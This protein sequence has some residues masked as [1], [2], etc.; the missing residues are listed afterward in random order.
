M[1]DFLGIFFQFINEIHID[2]HR[3]LIICHYIMLIMFFIII[4]LL[5]M[6]MSKRK[7]IEAELNESKKSLQNNLNFLRLV[8][9]TVP[10]PIFCKNSDGVYIEFNSEFEK[11][12]GLTREEILN[13]TAYDL[14]QGEYSKVYHEADIALM[15][16]RGMQTYESKVKYSDGKLHDIHFRKA[17]II[18][19]N[20]EVDGLVGIMIDFTDLKKNENKISRLLKINEAMLEINQSILGLDNINQ[21]F[22]LIL[23]KAL[24]IIDEAEYGS[25]L[26]LKNDEMLEIGAS[27]GYDPVK[28]KNFNLQLNHCFHWLK[29][30]G[31]IKNTV[32]IN[33]VS[34]LPG[35]DMTDLTE[36]LKQWSIKAS[37]STPIIIN[38]KL[39][40]MLNIDSN[41]INAFVEEDAQILQYM[42]SQ[43]EIA[44]NKHNLYKETI[45]LS[46][47]DKLTNL[48]NRSYFEEMFN[49]GF[50]NIINNNEEF[51]LV[52]FDLN[53]LK[54]VNDNYG[55]IAGDEYIK[56]F[57]KNLSNLFSSPDILARYGGD[58][59]IGIF[60]NTNDEILTEKFEK[61]IDYLKNNPL[62]FNGQNV[63]CSFSY[64]IAN[65]PT[66]SIIYDHLVIA[67]DV[68][69]YNYKRQR[70]IR[71]A[72]CAIS[73]KD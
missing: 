37:I 5:V 69:M 13:H 21:L 63:I 10:D 23:E 42:K 35:A 26:I 22:D 54:H 36:E 52:I 41:R 43:I 18:S 12:L 49:K 60:F 53:K 45:Y 15:K 8:L 2:H 64:G 34:K 61:L 72:S 40:G 38:Q 67:A 14:N 57:A 73:R 17:T 32:I 27:K 56:L 29:T 4:T 25:I 58:E 6:N 68:K 59:F 71:L 50:Q 31:N 46:K 44:I 65:F 1:K 16:T 20:N 24:S 19:E 47:Y 39:Y 3:G 7:K 55:H 62:N 48:Y 28:A 30:N 11:C 51:N 33:D 66:D 9:D 70:N